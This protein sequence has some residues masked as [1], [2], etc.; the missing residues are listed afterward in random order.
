MCGIVRVALFGRQRPIPSREASGDG[1]GIV[2][3]L[4]LSMAVLNTN[5]KLVELSLSTP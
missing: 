3:M 2:Y 4:K 1:A 5:C